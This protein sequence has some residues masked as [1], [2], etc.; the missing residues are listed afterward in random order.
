MNKQGERFSLQAYAM[1][2]GYIQ[3]TNA[4]KHFWDIE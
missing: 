1:W 3:Q 2:L 4:N